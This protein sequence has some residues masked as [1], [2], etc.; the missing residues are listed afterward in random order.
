L[1]G[2]DAVESNIISVTTEDVSDD[3]VPFFGR[4]AVGRS[5]TTRSQNAAR[6]GET[7]DG[8]KVLDWEP[9]ISASYK[10]EL[11]RPGRGGTNTRS[12]R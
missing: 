1:G 4:G 9:A 8:D 3:L 12:G 5:G 7:N 10:V 2:G 6:M 11:V